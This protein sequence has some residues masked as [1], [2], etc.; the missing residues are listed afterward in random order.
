MLLQATTIAER[1]RQP[2]KPEVGNYPDAELQW[3][4]TMAFNHAVDLL[5]G[6]NHAEATKWMDG[7]LGLAYWAR[8]EGALHALFTQKRALADER[9]S[10]RHG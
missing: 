6:G 7:A 10:Q 4:A 8:D 5:A 9:A 3:L 1:G 2:G